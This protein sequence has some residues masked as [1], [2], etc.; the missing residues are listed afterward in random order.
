MLCTLSNK[1]GHCVHDEILLEAPVEAGDKVVLILKETMEE[2]GGA[3]LKIFPVVF[4]I[5]VERRQF[6]VY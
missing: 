2:A 4:I 3:L 1:E 5:F 6:L